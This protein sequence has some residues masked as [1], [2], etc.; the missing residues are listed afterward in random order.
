MPSRRTVL[1]LAASIAALPVLSRGVRADSYPARAARILVGS[2][3]GG[4]LDLV[5]RLMAQWLTQRLGQSFVVE[6][7]AGAGTNIAADAVAHATPDGYTLLLLASPNA[8]NVT[9]YDNLNF[10]FQK[11]LVPVAPIERAPLLMAVN[12]T[13]PAKTVAEF[14]AYAKA[15]PG[16]I[17]QGSGGIG[18]TGHVAGELFKMMTGIEMAHVPY[19]GEPPALTDLI[20]GRVQVVFSTAGSLVGYMKA[21]TLRALGVTTKTDLAALAGVPPIAD[22]VPGYDAASW[23]GIAAPARTPPEVLDKLDTTINAG[24][25]D[26]TLVSRLADLGASADPASRAA[27]GAFVT[28]EVEK[29]RKVVKAAGLKPE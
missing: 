12:P 7:R 25:V 29:W 24:L 9:L 17:N 5:A 15:D 8:I 20:G 16:T 21:G 27:F 14:I 23:V 13:F 11:D 4:T 26:A 1:R 22:T 3:P 19:R 28:T 6:N 10:D 2:P 18:S